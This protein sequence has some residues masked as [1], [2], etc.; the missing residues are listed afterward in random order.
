MGQAITKAA[1]EDDSLQIVAGF[2]IAENNSLSYPVYTN[3]N[4]FTGEADVMID[5]SHPS[6][7]DDC[8]AFCKE[9][10]LPIIV[11]TTGL[12]EEQ[13]EKLASYS[14]TIPVFF[15]ANM[16]LGVNLI[17]ELAKKAAQ[18]LQDS[19][20]IEIIEK[21]H[22][23]KLDAPSGT[24]LSIADAIKT[25][26]DKEPEYVYERQSVRRKRSKQEIGIHSIRGGNIVGEHS[27]LFAGNDEVIE[28]KHTAQNRALFANGAIAAAKFMAGKPAGFYTMTDLFN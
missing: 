22:N 13:K 8:L 19:F 14:R 26:L 12:T 24:A 6:C 16:S 20:D 15:S 11:A 27:V 17:T 5:F 7:L 28:I 23:Q 10:A 25:A 9:R 3:Q 1:A 2:D 4:D 18:I 21:H